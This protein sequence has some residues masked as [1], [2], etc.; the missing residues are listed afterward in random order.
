MALENEGSNPFT[1]P[2]PFSVR[3]LGR[4][5]INFRRNLTFITIIA[6]VIAVTFSI[7]SC[8]KPSNGVNAQNGQIIAQNLEIPWALDFLPDGRLILTER[9]GR[10]RLIDAQGNL[11]PE[12]LLTI[13]EVVASGEGGLLGLA[14]HPNFSQNSFIYFY[15]T[16]RNDEGQLQNR[17]VRYILQ[18]GDSLQEDKVILDGI[19]AAGNHDGGRIK[20]GPDGLLYITAGD[21]GDSNSAQNLSALS[22]KIL[23]VKDDGSISE[24][25]PFPDSPVYSYGHRNPEGLA[26]D[27]EGRLWETEHGSSAHDEVNLIEAGKNYGWPVIQGDETVPDMVTPVINS[28][29]DTWAPSGAAVF[30][31]SL[32]FAGLR[33]ESLFELNLSDTTQLTRHL[34]RTYGRLRAVELGPDNTLYILTSNRD[35]RG[36]PAADDDRIIEISPAGL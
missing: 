3:C 19:P 34:Q 23:R 13:S 16:Y 4:W 10:I 33:G 9:P 32:Y 11:L 28:G 27:G 31:G 18:N 30:E 21:A 22:G 17:V 12:P 15:F 25:N 26:W 6:V 8:G 5:G 1:H 2:S 14:L 29:N 36:S 35:G 20:F 7:F 24:D